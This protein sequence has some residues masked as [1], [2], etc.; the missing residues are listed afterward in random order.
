MAR[1]AREGDRD[2]IG[3][4]SSRTATGA[5]FGTDCEGGRRE[6]GLEEVLRSL[7]DPAPMATETGGF[8]CCPTLIY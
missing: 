1:S 8:L 3:T 2:R 5:T 6:L 7:R 4:P